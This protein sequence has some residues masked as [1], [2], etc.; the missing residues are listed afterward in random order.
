VYVPSANNCLKQ[1]YYDYDKTGLFE[2]IDECSSKSKMSAP[3]AGGHYELHELF[4]PHMSRHE[5]E[6]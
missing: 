3:V 1:Y 4:V 2:K 5:P 6:Q